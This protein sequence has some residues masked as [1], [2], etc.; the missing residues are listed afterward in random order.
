MSEE[1]YVNL[2]Q[3][4]DE[5]LAF[6]SQSGNSQATDVLLN[7]YADFVRG[8]ARRFFLVGGE[9]EDL[10]QEGLMGLFSAIQS[11]KTEETDKSFKNFAYMCV[12]NK[13]IDAVKRSTSKKNQ[14]L[15]DSISE[16]IADAFTSPALSPEDVIIFMDE[17]LEIQQKMGALLSD[18]EFKIFTMY[19]GGMSCAEICNTTG[20][21]QKSVDNAVQRSK[22]KL[23]KAFGK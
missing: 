16:Q 3:Q 18:F 4:T 5:A 9:S 21:P 8:R 6:L 7:R 17:S 10:I 14:P 23:L 22:R 12:S 15:N 19:M 2:T 1:K 13:L 20:K 11:Y